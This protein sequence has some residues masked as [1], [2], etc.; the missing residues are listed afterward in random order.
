[1]SKGGNY[2][3]SGNKG[4][5]AFVS[6]LA[7]KPAQIYFFSGTDDF[8][9]REAL[10]M[11]VEQTL[12]AQARLLNYQ[13]FLG[14]DSSWGD[15]EIACVSMPLFSEKRVVAVMGVDMMGEADL[16]GLAKYV[17]R[18][19]ESTCLVL[20]SSSPGEESRRRGGVSISRLV[21]AFGDLESQ[22]AFW[23]ENREN[24][25]AWVRQWLKR[26]NRRM[27]EQ[28]QAEV[29]EAAEFSCYEAWNILEKALAAAA[30]AVEI[31]SEHVAMIGGAA[32]V[33]H[34]KNFK[35]AVSLADRKKAHLHAA[36]CL[37][38]GTQPT[39][40]VWSLNR[41]FRNAVR[42]S[43][44]PAGSGKREKDAA[45]IENLQRRLTAAQMCE[46]LSFLCETERGIKFGVLA[47]VLGVELLINELTR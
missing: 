1:M 37:E 21:S 11:L 22:Y 8:L 6:E 17:L 16:S 39:I 47:P 26:N 38:A 13:V 46:A 4:F 32:S 31:T 3:R 42:L 18:P 30:K 24:A 19:S 15:V 43:S 12:P 44:E 5:S 40:L 33:G 34:L 23:Q 36:K 9:K 45:A 29:L 2:R 7:A 14:A 25:R 10:G 27:R 35:L 41:C 20:A 28:C